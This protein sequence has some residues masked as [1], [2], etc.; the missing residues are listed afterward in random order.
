MDIIHPPA[1]RVVP[2]GFSITRETSMAVVHLHSLSLSFLLDIQ[3]RKFKKR[4]KI[5]GF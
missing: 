5:S 1:N 2:R 4:K 3:T